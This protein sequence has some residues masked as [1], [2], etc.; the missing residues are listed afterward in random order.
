VTPADLAR[1]RQLPGLPVK[2]Q[3][4]QEWLIPIAK[5]LPHKIELDADGEPVRRILGRYAAFY[6]EAGKYYDLLR[7]YRSGEPLT[8]A[9]AFAFAVE[10][11]A[12]NYRINRDVADFLEL[13]TEENI[14]WTIGATFELSELDAIAAQKKKAPRPPPALTSS[15]PGGPASCPTT[16]PRSSTS[17]SSPPASS[18][19]PPACP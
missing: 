4:G 9:G 17:I 7:G 1:N 11:L 13:F 6:A 12:L 15:P 19:P 3:D 16:S 14:L 18:L 2:L 8:I 10:A 5:Q